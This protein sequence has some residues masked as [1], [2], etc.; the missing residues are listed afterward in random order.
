M[1]RVL[2]IYNFASRFIDLQSHV[3]N[4]HMEQLTGYNICN[5]C[6]VCRK[7][8]S[9]KAFKILLKVSKSQKHF[10][11]NSIISC[12]FLGQWSF[13]KKCFWDLL[14]FKRTQISILC[15][16]LVFFWFCFLSVFFLCCCFWL[17]WCFWVILV[18]ILLVYIQNTL[19][20]FWNTLGILLEYFGCT[21]GNIWEYF[22]NTLGILWARDTLGIVWEYLV[23]TLEIR[24]NNTWYF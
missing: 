23:N 18:Y 6:K 1:F 16:F 14:T 15:S 17:F 8:F 19:G 22:G 24:Q 13:K 20:Y 12:S 9:G 2:G 3:T 21:L 4:S 7:Q 10:S 5:R 11:W